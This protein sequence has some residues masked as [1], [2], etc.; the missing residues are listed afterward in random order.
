[1][2]RLAILASALLTS[3]IVCHGLDTTTD[4]HMWNFDCHNYPRRRADDIREFM[5]AASFTPEG[6]RMADSIV[7]F[8]DDCTADDEPWNRGI[9]LKIACPVD[10][11]RAY[12]AIQRQLGT[13]DMSDSDRST[14]HILIRFYQDMC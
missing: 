6:A 13:T 8:L 1:M 9:M 12:E 2:W 4:K 7:R 14:Q 5:M 11:V 10:K 3:A